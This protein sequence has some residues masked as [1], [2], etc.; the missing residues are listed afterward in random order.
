MNQ[1]KKASTA[2][3][4]NSSVETSATIYNNAIITNSK[5]DCK[6]SVGDDSIIRNSI[7]NKYASIN[8]R[9]QIINSKVGLFS[10][11]GKGS[12]IIETQIGNYNSIS[13][14]VSIGASD[15]K[16]KNISTLPPWRFQLMITGINKAGKSNKQPK[17]F[18]GND[19][20]IT[21]NVVIKK[22]LTIGDGAVIGAGAVVTKDVEP[23]AVMAGVPARKIKMRFSPEH[24][25]ELLQ[26]KWWY[27][28]E[29]YITKFSD[30][31][32]NTPL[33]TESLS[34]MQEISKQIK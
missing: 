2:I 3:L 31:L 32:F 17:T 28:P 6:S 11:T 1:N 25:K 5:L 33:T 9:N 13:W 12:V 20:L 14:N 26:I 19:V 4:K 21:S 8:R 23:Y 30:L 10:Y 29:D 7:L 24:I 15:H 34:K 18:I 16:L 27:W 22:G